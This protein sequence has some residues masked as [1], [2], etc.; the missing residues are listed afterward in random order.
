L[1]DQLAAAKQQERD[2]VAAA[3]AK[4]QEMNAD[5]KLATKEKRI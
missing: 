4:D 3:A 5:C 1:V 2:R